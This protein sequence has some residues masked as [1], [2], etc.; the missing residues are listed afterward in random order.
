LAQSLDP[1][2]IIKLNTGIPH[3]AQPDN[4]NGPRKIMWLLV[5]VL[6]I[7]LTIFGIIYGCARAEQRGMLQLSVVSVASDHPSS[8]RK[9]RSGRRPM[10]ARAVWES[11]SE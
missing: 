9:L 2:R 3:M 4:R 8:E 5:V 7:T 10:A 1:V 6:L 11:G